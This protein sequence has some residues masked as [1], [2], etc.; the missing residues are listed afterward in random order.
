MSKYAPL[1]R[2]LEGRST[3]EAPMSFTQVEQILGFRLPASARKH[4]PW[5]ANTRGTHVHAA[6]WLDAGWKTSRVDIAGERLV[7][8]RAAADFAGVADS[9]SAEGF[10]V[11]LSALKP[12]TRRLLE[13]FRDEAGGDAAQAAIAVLDAA[14]ME[15]RRVL[16]ERFASKSPAGASDSAQFIREDRDGR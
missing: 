7:F 3:T 16:L 2:H 15:R 14:A 1:K 13:D 11:P 5:W 4:P 10:F 9:G 6:S 8:R 12:A